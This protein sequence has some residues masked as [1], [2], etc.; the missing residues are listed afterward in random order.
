MNA[1]LP[2]RPFSIIARAS[3]SYLLKRNLLARP[4]HLRMY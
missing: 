2:E 3:L 1:P 4:T